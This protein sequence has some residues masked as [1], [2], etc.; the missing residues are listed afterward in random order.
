M[1]HDDHVQSPPEGDPQPTAYALRGALKLPGAWS[2]AELR[3]GIDLFLA[4]L[5]S[6]LRERGCRLIGHI[7]GI[8]E[9]GD[10]GHLFFSVTSF[11]QKTRFKGETAGEYEKVG[12]TLNVIVYGVG[13]DE[14]EQLVLE[15]LSTHL[16]EVATRG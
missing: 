10:K 14:V 2:E 9:T 13:N 6:S 4:G 8:L 3:K 11:E 5:T 12:L 15:G 16:G 7:K 1:S